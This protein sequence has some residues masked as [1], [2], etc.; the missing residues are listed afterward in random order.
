LPV[1][2]TLEPAALDAFISSL[3]AAGFEPVGDQ[4]SWIGPLHPALEHLTAERTMRVEV[5]DGWPYLHPKV[6]VQGLAAGLHRN[7]H[8]DICLWGD[9]DPSL[10]WLTWDGIAHRITEWVAGAPSTATADDPALDA[11]RY[12]EVARKG[13]ATIDLTGID[14]RYWGAREARGAMKDDLLAIGEGPLRGR[15]YT[16]K[17]VQTPPKNLDGVRNLLR[18][19]QRKDLD[20]ALRTVGLPEGVS[21]LVLVWK[22]AASP[23]LL[24]L[25]LERTN[26]S[27]TAMS[28]EAARA[29]LAVLLLRAGPDAAQLRERAVAVL[30]VGAI[31]SQVALLLARSGV[32]TLS[33]FDPQRLRP[34]DVVRHASSS[35][36]VGKPKVASLKTGIYM[37]APWTKVNT[38]ERSHWE[39]SQLAEI[40]RHV[41]L[42]VDAVGVASFTEQLARVCE[43]EARRL[44]SV[45]LYRHGDVGRVRLQTARP[46]ANLADR[47]TDARF[48][49]VPPGVDEAEVAW[50]AGCGA[51]IAQASP[52]A[53]ASAA[54]AAA[55]LA[56]EALCESETG[57]VDV[58][59]VYRPLGDS[60][61][62]VIGSRTYRPA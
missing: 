6:Y 53:V 38:Y 7:H 18:R 52:A 14:I 23:N 20:R 13:L 48:P 29:D 58:I 25:W 56:V 44:L 45:A 11:H 35:L 5:R 37:Q 55:R 36:F 4:R 10:A 2:D 34:G 33:L 50:E 39:P 8:G 43:V 49:T 19:R 30:G 21:F 60:P 31:G 41:D 42:V 46:V 22:N 54:A 12:F 62:D 32:G 24:I 3:L 61:F 57:D 1:P 15:L 17:A 51:P 47:A 28:I 40:A 16:L 9:G 27:V 59:E 26:G